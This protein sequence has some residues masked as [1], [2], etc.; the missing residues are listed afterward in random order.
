MRILAALVLSCSY[1]LAWCQSPP[2]EEPGFIHRAG[3]GDTL[4]IHVTARTCRGSWFEKY[5]MIWT[6]DGTMLR[7]YR[8]RS[9][10]GVM[11]AQGKENPRDVDVH[12]IPFELFKEYIL[13]DSDLVEFATF[14]SLGIECGMV[15]RHAGASYR[16][17]EFRLKGAVHRFS[18]EC[19]NFGERR[20]NYFEPYRTEVRE[21]RRRQ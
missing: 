15:P 9:L 10:P 1:I 20:L 18:N 21:A 14:E 7:T 17:F 3:S 13:G 16:A 8:H 19:D 2:G 12:R 5:E 11:E 6:P 4:T